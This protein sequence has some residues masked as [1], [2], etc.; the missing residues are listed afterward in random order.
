VSTRF[1]STKTN[2][3][4][5]FLIDRGCCR[6]PRRR[7]RRQRRPKQVSPHQNGTTTA[8]KRKHAP[9]CFGPTTSLFA[10][11]TPRACSPFWNTSKSLKFGG[12]RGNLRI[13]TSLSRGAT[14]TATRFEGLFVWCVPDYERK[15]RRRPYQLPS[16]VPR[17]PC[18]S[19]WAAELVELAAPCWSPPSLH[20]P[21]SQSKRDLIANNIRLTLARAAKHLAI[22]HN[23]D[24]DDCSSSSG[25]ATLRLSPS[26]SPPLAESLCKKPH[27]PVSVS[28]RANLPGGGV[29]Q[30]QSSNIAT[31]YPANAI[32][33][34]RLCPFDAD[35]AKATVERIGPRRRPSCS[36]HNARPYTANATDDDNVDAPPSGT[37]SGTAGSTA[38][39]TATLSTTGGTPACQTQALLQGP[40]LGK[41]L[42]KW[43]ADGGDCH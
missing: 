35:C 39:G 34:E 15:K 6:H 25:P 10:T 41:V 23:V 8:L 16:G 11:S 17:R 33:A 21:S 36:R 32:A 2:P 7:R 28:C 30:H 4:A 42:R 27:P 20:V 18:L 31:F 13:S 1:S 5:P 26:P 38:S 29:E 19:C 9:S 40:G 3:T 12:T 43:A 22:T 24:S 37:F 14:T